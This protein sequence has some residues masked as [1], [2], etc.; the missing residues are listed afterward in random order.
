MPT[1]APT[2]KVWLPLGVSDEMGA[3]TDPIGVLKDGPSGE[4]PVDVDDGP[5]DEAGVVEG[6]DS[7]LP[8]VEDIDEPDDA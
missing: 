8:V 3:V 1:I 6:C 7:M 5:S 4:V 2:G